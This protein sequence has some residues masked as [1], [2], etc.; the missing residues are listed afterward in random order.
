MCAPAVGAGGHIDEPSNVP[1]RQAAGIAN[2]H[3]T[4]GIRGSIEWINPEGVS[5]QI[6]ALDDFGIPLLSAPAVADRAPQLMNTAPQKT[7]KNGQKQTED[8]DEKLT[9]SNVA[10]EFVHPCGFGAFPRLY[11]EFPLYFVLVGY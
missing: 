8:C 3:M 1:S 2:S 9:G 6:R 4:L 11:V 5:T 7:G 10:H